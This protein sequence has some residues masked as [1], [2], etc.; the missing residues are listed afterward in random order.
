MPNGPKK[1]RE[2][3]SW[4]IN[5]LPYETENVIID[6][7][8]TKRRTSRSK[9][10]LEKI[11]RYKNRL[12]F[13]S[14]GT[15][16]VGHRVGRT[17]LRIQG[18][19]HHLMEP[20]MPNDGMKLKFAQIYTLDGTQD[21]IDA[22]QH[23]FEGPNQHTLLTAQRCLRSINPY[24]QGFERCYDRFKEDEERHP[25]GTMSVECNSSTPNARIAVH[26]MA[27][28]QPRLLAS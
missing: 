7:Q 24:V 15:S 22:R 26:T 21:Q 3:Q 2:L 18:P 25:I 12:S 10:F 11:V 19:V 6:G 28:P 16:N 4:E 9:E 13:T 5:G 20:L 14:E 8:P 1:D 23:Y 27:L 17:T